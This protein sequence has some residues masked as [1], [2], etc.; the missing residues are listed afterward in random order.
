MKILTIFFRII[1]DD[2]EKM[3]ERAE[4]NKLFIYIKIPEVPI[5]V[6]Y[7]GKHFKAYLL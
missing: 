4:K 7:K 5:K 1:K 3:K 2:V 6:S